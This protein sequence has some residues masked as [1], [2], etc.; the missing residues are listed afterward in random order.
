MSSVNKSGGTYELESTDRA[1]NIAQQVAE[2]LNSTY[3]ESGENGFAVD[4]Y[5]RFDFFPT[6]HFSRHGTILIPETEEA[7][8][9]IDSYL[10][11]DENEL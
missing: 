5:T 4:G 6:R 1:A 11:E 7:S 9:M 3:Q 8:E 2:E 10:E